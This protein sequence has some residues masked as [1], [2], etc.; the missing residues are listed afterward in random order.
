MIK[1]GTGKIF[2]FFNVRRKGAPPQYHSHFIT[3]R[4]EEIFEDFKFDGGNVRHLAT[5][6]T[7]YR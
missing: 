5:F 6:F 7:I 3:N 2:S 4:G 1:E